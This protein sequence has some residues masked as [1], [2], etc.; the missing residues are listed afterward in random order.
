MTKCDNCN[1]FHNGECWKPSGKRQW[2]GKDREM[3]NK[4][5]KDLQDTGSSAQ[6]N[7]VIEGKFVALQT[8]HDLDDK[9]DSDVNVLTGSKYENETY[10]YEWLANLAATIH[11][12]NRCDAFATYEELPNTTVSGVG[13]TRVCIVGKGTIY[14]HSLCDGKVHTLQLNDVFH[15]PKTESNI[16]SIGCWEEIWGRGLLNKYHKVTLTAEDDVPIAR[17]PKLGNKLYHLSFALA[18]TPPSDT[19]PEPAC[20][21]TNI[22]KLPW[23][24]L[25]RCFRHISYSGLEKLVRLDLV[26]GIQ[27]DT[28]SPKLDCVETQYSLLM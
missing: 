24:I 21:T 9:L 19:E 8:E 4:K 28:K 14:L 25:H 22:Q 13:G 1:L 20:F 10:D 26:D 27:V 15:I 12:T 16:L 18:T 17:G 6:A 23:E 11:V 3:S 5:K 7:V 2:K